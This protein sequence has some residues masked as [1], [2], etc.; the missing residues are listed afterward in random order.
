MNKPASSP[1]DYAFLG[2]CERANYVRD[3]NSNVFKWNVL[4]LKSIVL[5]HFFPLNLGGYL[6]G[7][8]INTR[9]AFD[10][11]QVILVDKSGSQVG[12]LDFAPKT[13]SPNEEDAVLHKETPIVMVPEVGWVMFFAQLGLQSFVITK[14]GLYYLRITR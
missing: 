5:S 13:V 3:G 14:P 12:T 1:S 4:G 9:A 7:F 11:K 10:D 8:A 6:L 2:I